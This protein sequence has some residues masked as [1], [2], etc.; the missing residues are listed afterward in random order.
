MGRP[1]MQRPGRPAHARRWMALAG[2]VPVATVVVAVALGWDPGAW[3][4]S[5]W[6]SFRGA[7]F[8]Y[9]APAL[10]V[11]TAQTIFAA[12]A[13]LAIL[14][15]AYPDSHVSRPVVLA[16]YATGTALNNFLPANAGSLV[17]VAMLLATVSGATAAGVVAA[18]AVEKL[19]WAVLATLV[20]LYL[21]L[22][23]GGSF[24]QKFGF[25]T[26]HPW[27]TVLVAVAAVTVVVVAVRLA[28]RWLRRLWEQ[29]KQGGR[30]LS[31]RRAYAVGVVVPQFL[32]WSCKLGVTALLLTAYGIPLGFHTL[33]SVIGGNSL[34]NVASVTP[35]GVGVNQALNVASL[36]HAAS[37]AAAAAYSLGQQL[38]TTTWSL[39]MAVVFVTAAFGWKTGVR[40]V[41]QSIG[42]QEQVREGTS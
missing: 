21:F 40:L 2:A 6:H 36:H 5:V 32:A 39:A 20:Y 38:L 4:D 33:M 8:G 23:V 35:G 27:A 10:A 19:F 37:A 34:A 24:A 11:Q 31:D 13:W 30:I 42:R 25:V 16:C 22:S 9:V 15:H 29:A 18:A 41:R 14:R 3:L 7:S 17:T 26:E 1:I 12:T 28:W